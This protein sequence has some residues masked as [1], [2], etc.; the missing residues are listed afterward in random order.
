MFP[1]I[2]PQ[3]NTVDNMTRGGKITV[4]CVTF[5]RNRC[6]KKIITAVDHP[7]HFFRQTYDSYSIKLHIQVHLLPVLHAKYNYLIAT[8]VLCDIERTTII[9]TKF[10]CYN[11]RMTLNATTQNCPKFWSVPIKE[12][13]KQGLQVKIC[14]GPPNPANRINFDVKSQ[15]WIRYWFSTIKCV[16]WRNRTLF[17]AAW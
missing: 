9:T 13:K 4:D 11:W 1:V 5:I 15:K 7:D 14:D 2:V 17:W 8:M 6:E 3:H 12:P 16:L 10:I